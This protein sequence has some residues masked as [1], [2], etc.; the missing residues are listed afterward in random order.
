MKVGDRKDLG[1]G[2]QAVVIDLGDP[3]GTLDAI[4]KLNDDEFA[5]VARQIGILGAN[6]NII[7]TG[8]LY[9]I[10]KREAAARLPSVDLATMKPMTEA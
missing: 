8:L 4:R 5:E 2:I 6:V 10:R 3:H 1:N 9:E 7:G